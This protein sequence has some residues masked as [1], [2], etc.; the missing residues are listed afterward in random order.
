MYIYMLLYTDIGVYI[1][2]HTSMYNAP[3]S[4]SCTRLRNFTSPQTLTPLKKSKG[5]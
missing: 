2:S 1:Y 4:S 3:V 5:T